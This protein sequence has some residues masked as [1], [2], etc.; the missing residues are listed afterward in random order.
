MFNRWRKLLVNIC[1]DW[2]TLKMRMIVVTQQRPMVCPDL[3]E[4]G[5]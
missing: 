4:L 1:C 2:Q 3:D 5:Q